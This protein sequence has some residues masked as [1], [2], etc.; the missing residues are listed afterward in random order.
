MENKT[1]PKMKC[2]IID[3]EQPA[4][5][6]LIQLIGEISWLEYVG[7]CYSVVE[8]VELIK[9]L[10]PDI[11]FLDVQMPGISGLEL[12]PL[13]PSPRPHIIIT[14][15]FKQYALDGFDHAVTDYLLKPITSAR[16]LQAVLKTKNEAS[17]TITLVPSQNPDEQGYTWVKTGS[18]MVQILLNDIIAVEGMGD[19][20]KIHCKD[21]IIVKYSSIKSF[22]GE[23]PADQFIRIH[24]SY[25]VNRYAVKS[26]EGNVVMM[27]NNKEYRIS[28][29]GSRESV[30]KQ[31]TKPKI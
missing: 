9:E 28:S 19:Y 24:R 10:A 21:G 27:V 20:V 31:L 2:V 17:R 30:I 29:R 12:I 6:A 22:L 25:I 18:K 23:L 8:A 5:R 16:F 26:I 15:G 13:L 4:H 3:D 7:S 14:S 1:I 11:I